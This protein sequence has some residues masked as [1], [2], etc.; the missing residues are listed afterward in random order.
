MGFIK[1]FKEFAV[2]GNV[3][4]LAVGL[5]IGAAFAK[6]VDSVI[7]DLIM[8]VVASII[9][10]PDFSNA[11]I[12]LRANIPYGLPIAAAKA[13]GPVFAYGNFITVA[14]NFLLLALAI[15]ILIKAI[16]KL[17]RKTP[18]PAT[19]KAELSSTDKLLIEIRDTLKGSYDRP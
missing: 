6:I 15:F 7:N 5:I 13:R 14:I 4:D 18:P 9:G 17:K 12:P 11:Y 8:P 3:I 10:S 1:E 2:K 19:T 16:N